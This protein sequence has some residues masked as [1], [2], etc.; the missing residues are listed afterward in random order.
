M[1]IKIAIF[2]A[3]VLISLSYFVWAGEGYRLYFNGVPDGAYGYRV[4]ATTDN[5]K[6]IAVQMQ[7]LCPTADGANLTSEHYKVATKSC[8]YIR[9]FFILEC[10]RYVKVEK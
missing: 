10:F 4:I 8:G 2:L 1:K 6:D 5:W 3:V 9:K 7:R